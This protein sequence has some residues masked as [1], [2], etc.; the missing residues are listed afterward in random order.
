LLPAAIAWI[1]GMRPSLAKWAFYD[2]IKL[3]RIPS[4]SIMAAGTK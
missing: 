3:G 1:D 2:L 4:Q